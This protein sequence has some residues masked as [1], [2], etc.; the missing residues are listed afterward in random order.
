[1][2]AVN[3][4][5]DEL[6]EKVK[7]NRETHRDT[8]DKAQIKYREQIVIELD[9]MLDDARKGRKIR[10]FVELPEPEDHTADYDQIIEMLMMSTDEIIKL[11]YQEFRTFV[12]DE[13]GWKAAWASNTA[14]YLAT[15]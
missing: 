3:V 9:R 12:M 7:A 8:F 14:S 2:Q 6:L 13:W 10:R 4:N 1:M 15:S 5:K 11:N